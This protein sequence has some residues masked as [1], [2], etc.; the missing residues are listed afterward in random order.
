LNK[1]KNNK[2]RYL[3]Q[4]NTLIKKELTLEWRQKFAINGILLY[5]ASTI[6]ICYMSFRLKGNLINPITW[7]ALFWIIIVFTAINSI[8]KSFNQEREG[9]QLYYYLIANPQAIILSK[10]IYNSGLMLLLSLI[11]YWVYGLI[12]N[13]PV[14]NHWLFLINL[15]LASTGFA[16]TLTLISAIA[17]KANN[18]GA[19][20]AVLS[21]PVMLPMLLIVI[22]ISKNAMDGLSTSTSMDEILTL[23][24]INM[25]VVTVSYLLFPYLW[26][27]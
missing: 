3:K 25:I 13:N 6:F 8:S 27:S 26:R 23:V 20:M 2:I 19:L 22:K 4:L 12:M 9:R 11:G 21:F 10:I 14:E 24:A 17:S 7:N 18:S 1:E 15:C 5:L 16:S